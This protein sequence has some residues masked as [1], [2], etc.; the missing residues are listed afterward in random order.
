[1]PLRTIQGVACT[2]NLFFFIAEQ[3]FIVQMCHLFMHSP[4]EG[5]LDCFQFGVITIR[6]VMNKSTQ[7]FLQTLVF[8]SNVFFCD[9][10]GCVFCLFLY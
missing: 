5:H 3:N 6:A 10:P 2:N 8:I 4:V 1:M 7:D 9:L